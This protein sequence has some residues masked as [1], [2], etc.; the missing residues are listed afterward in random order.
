MCGPWTQAISA[1]ALSHAPL[2][3]LYVRCIRRWTASS[4][5]RYLVARERPCKMVARHPECPR[6]RPAGHPRRTCVH[7]MYVHLTNPVSASKLDTGQPS[8]IRG[9]QTRSQSLG[10]VAPHI[11]HASVAPLPP[12]FMKPAACLGPSASIMCDQTFSTGPQRPP[13]R[14]T[15]SRGG[16]SRPRRPTSRRWCGPGDARSGAR[17]PLRGVTVQW[18][19]GQPNER[20]HPTVVLV[21]LPCRPR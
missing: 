11:L 10:G 1:T 4:G 6:S 21:V 9:Q 20:V 12:A 3:P 16:G 13:A 18:L 2:L 17:P 8:Y 14:G 5:L 15:R 7:C 19:R